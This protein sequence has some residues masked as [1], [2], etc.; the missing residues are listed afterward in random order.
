MP[1]EKSERAPYCR[2]APAAPFYHCKPLRLVSIW[3]WE[4]VFI[5]LFF[6]LSLHQTAETPAILLSL[7]TKA[8]GQE[9]SYQTSVALE[10]EAAYKPRGEFFPMLRL[11][12]F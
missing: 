9:P 5:W 4:A 11:D 6:L 7:L 2:A 3:T 12:C 1:Q 8:D 10:D